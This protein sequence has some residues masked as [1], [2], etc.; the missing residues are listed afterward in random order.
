MSLSVPVH[1]CDVLQL[2]GRFNNKS[3]I[4]VSF[5]N[6]FFFFI[7]KVEC[8]LVL[9]HSRE[10]ERGQTSPQQNNSTTGKREKHAFFFGFGGELAL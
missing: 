3:K 7:R 6:V 9:L 10:R 5:S 1:T 2:K 8:H 4:H